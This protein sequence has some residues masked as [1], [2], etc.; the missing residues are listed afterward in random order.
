MLSIKNEN[1]YI[2]VEDSEGNQKIHINDIGVIV[3]IINKL[4]NE[5]IYEHNNVNEKFFLKNSNNFLFT[6]LLNEKICQL[7]I[8][9]EADPIYIVVNLKKLS[10]GEFLLDP[11]T[12]KNITVEKPLFGLLIFFK[13]YLYFKKVTTPI[14]EE[15]ESDDED[16]LSNNLCKLYSQTNNQ[17]NSLTLKP[18]LLNIKNTINSYI[19]NCNN[20]IELVQWEQMFNQFI[21]DI[22]SNF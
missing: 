3:R 9:E 12:K 21:E 14:L 1:D 13:N 4:N 17:N 10:T 18:E 7:N 11:I 16:D 15:D 22:S 6:T 20:L 8:D 19:S 5:I 2:F